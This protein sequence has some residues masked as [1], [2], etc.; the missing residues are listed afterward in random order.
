MRIVLRH[1]MASRASSATTGT[2][3]REMSLGFTALTGAMSTQAS[4]LLVCHGTSAIELR[5][6]YF[7]CSYLERSDG[8]I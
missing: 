6:Y 2:S 3:E 4:P 1:R 5:E 8:V 7:T